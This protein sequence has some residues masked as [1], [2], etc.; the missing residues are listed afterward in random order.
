MSYIIDFSRVNELT[1]HPND[2]PNT[3]YQ[4][5]FCYY[6]S[7]RYIKDLIET[8]L[9]NQGDCQKYNHAVEILRFNKILLDKSD[10]RDGKIDEII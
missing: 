10:L 6:I 3:G 2:N 1:A 9:N 5:T 8:Y 4:G 7:R